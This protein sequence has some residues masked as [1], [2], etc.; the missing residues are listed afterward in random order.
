MQRAALL[1]TLGLLAGAIAMYWHG[2]DLGSPAPIAL[3]AEADDAAVDDAASVDVDSG[4]AVDFLALVTGSIS[5]AERAALLRLAAQADRATLQSLAAQVAALPALPGRALALEV[6]LARYAEL[7][8]PAA[9][10]FAREIDAPDAALEPLFSTWAQ[11]DP[12]AA[13]RAL[14]DFDPRTAMTL[15]VVVLEVLG[16]DDLGLARVVGAV[17]QIDADRLRAAGAIAKADRDPEAALA[18]VALVAP[19]K[20]AQAV[21]KIMAAWVERDIYGALAHLDLMTD[22]AFRGEVRNALLREWAAVDPDATLRYML[23]LDPDAQREALAAGM[24]VFALIDPERALAAAATV[25][26]ELGTMIRRGAL[27][28]LARDDPLAALRHAETLP[29]NE[30][31]QLF[32]LVATS[33]ARTDLEAALAWAQNLTPSVPGVLGNVLAELARVDVAR[34][35]DLVAQLPANDQQRMFQQLVMT[36][37][38]RAEAMVQVAD[39]MLAAG[40]RPQMLQMVTSLWAQRQPEDALRWWFANSGRAPRAM[41]PQAGMRLGQTDPNAAIGYLDRVPSAQRATWLSAVAAGYAQRDPAGAARWVGEHRGEDGYEAAVAAVAGQSASNDPIAA[42]GLLDSI[43]WSRAPDAANA[44]RAVAAAWARREPRAA[45]SWVAALGND[46]A[47]TA[48]TAALSG[49]WARRDLAGA[50][51]WAMELPASPA[52]DA[53][54]VQVLGAA[55]GTTLDPGLLDAFSSTAA[56]DR[57]LSQAVSM[58]AQR[59]S[60]AAHAIAD[61]YITDPT[62]RQQAERFLARGPLDGFIQQAPNLPV[63]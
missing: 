2:R 43:E 22:D 58:I 17:P 37:A 23:E 18:D 36:N 38:L 19:S 27:M 8:A 48:A 28:G 62:A 14:G 40:N 39:R 57:G 4:G 59:D 1:F 47:K 6:L 15:A 9:A 33:Y 53:A 44:A 49:A 35:L 11:R 7:D 25:P 56:R 21:S 42:A 24:Q 20:R 34:A 50:R 55:T 30:R 13:L 63:R 10:R 3:H 31:S 29:A 12:S 41:L 32:N 46:D 51:G 54:I 60:D 16:N 45:A 26:G 52:R 5:V 61:R